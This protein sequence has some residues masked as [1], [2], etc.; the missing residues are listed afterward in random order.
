MVKIFKK[1]EA[2]LLTRWGC[3]EC[4]KVTDQEIIGVRNTP[5]YL[6]LAIKCQNTEC[7]NETEKS[8]ALN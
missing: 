7:G 5:S 3:E 1:R 2:L 4:K 8:F 6:I